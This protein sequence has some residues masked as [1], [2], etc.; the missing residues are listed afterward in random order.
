MRGGGTLG[1]A[2]WQVGAGLAGGALVIG[3]FLAGAPVAMA[4]GTPADYPW[5]VFA[6]GM[7]LAGT[8]AW[9]AFARGAP[10]PTG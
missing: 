9:V 5:P 1:V 6:A 8:A 10:Q 3:S 2:R 4:G 7:L